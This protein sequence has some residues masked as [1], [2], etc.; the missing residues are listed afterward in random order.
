MP[1]VLKFAEL[2]KMKGFNAS[3]EIPDL[4]SHTSVFLNQKKVF[5][6][7]IRPAYTFLKLA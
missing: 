6:K 3:Q 4:G 5:E 1:Y 7:T 2:K